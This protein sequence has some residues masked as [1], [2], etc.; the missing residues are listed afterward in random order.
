V[1]LTCWRPRQAAPALQSLRVALC[2]ARRPR[3]AFRRRTITSDI[4]HKGL[5]NLSVD[6]VVE[7]V[8]LAMDSY[9]NDVRRDCSAVEFGMRRFLIPP[10]SR[11]R[12][13]GER[14]LGHGGGLTPIASGGEAGAVAE[15]GQQC[16]GGPTVPVSVSICI[17]GRL[18]GEPV[19]SGHQALR[20]D[21]VIRPAL[22]CSPVSSRPRGSTAHCYG[23]VRRTGR[24]S[25]IRRTK[26]PRGR[27]GGRAGSSVRSLPGGRAA[28]RGGRRCHQRARPPTGTA[29]SR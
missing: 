19:F 16:G 9:G 6:V 26:V 17:Q 22:L 25:R 23:S 2:V 8:L 24:W 11:R 5:R 13:G 15:G 3:S 28:G 10:S 1:S 18:S 7:K 29:C 21:G 12:G 4:G 14:G 27:G 20:P